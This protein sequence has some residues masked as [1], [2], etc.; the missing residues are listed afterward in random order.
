MRYL[1]N[2]FTKKKIDKEDHKTVSYTSRSLS[3]TYR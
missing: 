2:T 1:D 3:P